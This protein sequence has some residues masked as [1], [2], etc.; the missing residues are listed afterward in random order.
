MTNIFTDSTAFNK[1]NGNF[2]T[3]YSE[4]RKTIDKLLIFELKVC[5]V[6]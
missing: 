5:A 3:Q 6:N 2:N 4:G 1:V